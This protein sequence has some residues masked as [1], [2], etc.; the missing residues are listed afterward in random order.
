V[1]Q[2]SA[3]PLS[4]ADLSRRNESGS[5]HVALIMAAW[6]TETA[7]KSASLTDLPRSTHG[8]GLI[9]TILHPS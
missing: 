9:A 1:P 5:K 2:Q 6:A 3:P 7:H 8:I 4:A